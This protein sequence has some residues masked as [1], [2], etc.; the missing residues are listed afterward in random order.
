MSEL[1]RGTA[2]L[3]WHRAIATNLARFPKAS[4][5]S[6]AFAGFLIVLVSSTGPSVLLLQAAKVGHFTNAQTLSWLALCWLGSAGYAI[7][8]SLR[9][10]IPMIGA[11]SSPSAALLVT[12]F[13]THSI[14]EAVG[15][16]FISALGLLIIG[17][18]GAYESIMRHV[19]KAIT[20]AMLGG[21][22]FAFGLKVFVVLPDS[23]LLV[24]SMLLAYLVARSLRWRAPAVPSLVIGFIIAGAR[25]QLHNPHLHLSI[26]HPTWVRPTFS[27]IDIFTIAIPLALL[28]LSTQ[29]APG[30]AVIESNGYLLP[31]KWMLT[32]GSLLSLATAGFLGSGVNSAAISAAIGISPDA[33]ADK[34]RRYTAGIYSGLFYLLIGLFAS[35]MMALFFSLPASM[36]AALASLAL[37]PSIA[38]STHDALVQPSYREPAMI[39]FLVT[40]S[41]IHILKLGA[42]FWGLVAG[43]FAHWIIVAG[44][45]IGRK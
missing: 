44:S 16:Y 5:F 2:D 22:L 14:P 41:N 38:S 32:T 40:V 28:T 4:S 6:A 20:M 8:L 30:S 37:L 35:A 31:T 29:Y 43:V 25:H 13:A 24:L 10:G 21:V 3:P 23:P 45:K 18:T 11:W 36:L 34:S 12:T 15:A 42:P 26:V 9:F 19:P 39:T 33:E 17:V 1:Y 7:F 27:I